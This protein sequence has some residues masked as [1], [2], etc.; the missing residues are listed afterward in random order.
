MY[1]SNVCLFGSSLPG[2]PMIE[3]LG[4]LNHIAVLVRD[5]PKALQRF[6]SLLGAQVIEQEHLPSS[7]T[8]VAVLEVAGAHLELLSS[9]EPD[10]KVGKLLAASG[11]GIHHLSFEVQD[12]HHALEQ[13]RHA[14][15]RLRDEVPRPGLHGRPIAFLDPQDTCGVLIELV[16]ENPDGKGQAQ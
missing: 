5:L 1:L 3:G 11:E 4:R 15:I 6:R 9:R 16:Q 8:D 13:C 14:G 12:I 10:T 2:L 7:A